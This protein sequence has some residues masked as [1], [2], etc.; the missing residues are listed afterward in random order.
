MEGDEAIGE[1]VA[2]DLSGGGGDTISGDTCGE[3]KE[4]L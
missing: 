3:A 4:K 1:T 2:S